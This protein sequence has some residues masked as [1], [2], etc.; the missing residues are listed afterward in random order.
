ML[1]MI[2]TTC[3]ALLKVFSLSKCNFKF[4]L[5]DMHRKDNE[6][7]HNSTWFLRFLKQLY[8]AKLATR[9]ISSIAFHYTMMVRLITSWKMVCIQTFIA[10]V[11]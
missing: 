10:V 6:V 5:I 9:T 7:N 8:L 1:Q 4:P 3:S 11:D 2:L